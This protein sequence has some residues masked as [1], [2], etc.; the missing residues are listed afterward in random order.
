MKKPSLYL[1]DLLDHLDAVRDF[2]LDG[3]ETFLLDR[4]TQMAVIRAYEVVGEI[5]KR[6]PQ[7]LK[8]ANPQINWKKL[9]GFRDFLTHNYEEVILQYVWNAVEDLPNLRAAVEAV[10]ASLPDNDSQ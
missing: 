8:D 5:V 1:N 2:T 7:S 6:L 4:R 3:R 9:I 10:L